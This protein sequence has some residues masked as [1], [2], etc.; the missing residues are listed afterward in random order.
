MQ[1][2]S[3]DP[4]SPDKTATPSTLPDRFAEHLFE[5]FND[6]GE[7][8]TPDQQ[9]L[10]RARIDRVVNYQAVIGILGKTG[11]GKSSLCNALFG[12]DI[13][14]ISDVAAG[15]REPQEIILALNRGR[16]ITLI[17]M[18]GVGESLARDGEYAALYRSLLPRLD[19]VLWLVKGDDR[20]LSVD[21]QCFREVVQPC[22]IQ[23]GMR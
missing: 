2:A 17:D 16:G 13:A 9:A 5:L 23:A 22:A 11:S 19:L 3:L 8:L 7:Q 18:P 1:K 20:A 15:T 10:L 14:T 6:C 21:E 4:A 12:A